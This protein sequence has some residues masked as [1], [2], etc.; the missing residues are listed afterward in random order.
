MDYG[1][2]CCPLDLSSNL[3]FYTSLDYFCAMR[4][5]SKATFCKRAA[6]PSAET[7]LYFQAERLSKTQKARVVSH[8]NQCDFC[9]AE[10]HLL[11]H[12]DL[13]E[14]RCTQTTEI[15]KHLQKLVESIL[16]GRTLRQEFSDEAYE[17]EIVS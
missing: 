8:L 14:A 16:K 6:C 10:L 12:H 3:D 5:K 11:S 15:P 13:A 2:D 17:S 1:L 4:V 7:L 9:R